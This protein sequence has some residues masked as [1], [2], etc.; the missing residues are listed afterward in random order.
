MVKRIRRQAIRAERACEPGRRLDADFVDPRRA[1]PARIVI[2]R[3]FTLTGNVLN[4]RAAKGDVDN[5]DAT[6]DCERWH[7]TTTCL[8]NQGD[9]ARVAAL[10]R[11]D[12]GMRFLG[13]TLR[14]DV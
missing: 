13:I 4:E 1:G 6:A 12:A 14:G 8:Q 7:T 11:L 10:V 2:D 3:T 9:L 5:L